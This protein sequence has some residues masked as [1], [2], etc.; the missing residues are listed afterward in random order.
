[1]ESTRLSFAVAS[2]ADR[3]AFFRRNFGLTCALLPFPLSP[4]LCLYSF[5][6]S[7]VVRFLPQ[8]ICPV[9]MHEGLRF[10]LREGGRTVGA[11]VVSS[12][13]E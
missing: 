7:L 6:P 10:A 9:V 5:L 2:T 1:M 4:F 8:L 11:G 3:S 12:I 13:V